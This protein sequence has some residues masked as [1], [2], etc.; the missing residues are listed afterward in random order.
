MPP[1]GLPVRSEDGT[2]LRG[3][4][5]WGLTP[6]CLGWWGCPK[7]RGGIETLG[8]LAPLLVH[9][10]GLPRIT[11]AALERGQPVLDRGQLLLNRR[12]G[13]LPHE[14]G[15]INPSIAHGHPRHLGRHDFLDQRGGDFRDRVDQTRQALQS[16]TS[17]HDLPRLAGACGLHA[18]VEHDPVAL[19]G[20]D[21]ERHD[22]TSSSSA[23]APAVHRASCSPASAVSPLQRTRR[24]AR[25]I[26]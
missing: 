23:S 18:L 4:G 14:L 5:P 24:S 26:S 19:A 10:S 25:S 6:L 16:K 2:K 22:A 11:L 9:R 3:N 17:L 8:K 12:L 21:L 1:D 13:R 15:R 20:H 7:L